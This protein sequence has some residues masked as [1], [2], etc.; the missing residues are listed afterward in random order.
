MLA[1]ED[2]E[3][4][5]QTLPRGVAKDVSSQFQ[6]LQGQF[7]QLPFFGFDDQEQRGRLVHRE[8]LVN[9][10]DLRTSDPHFIRITIHSIRVWR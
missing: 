6:I 1:T 4:L 7:E 3:I 9:F 8:N 10:H 2:P 5:D